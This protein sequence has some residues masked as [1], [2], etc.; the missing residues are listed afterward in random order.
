MRRYEYKCVSARTLSDPMYRMAGFIEPRAT[1]S[2]DSPSQTH[3]SGEAVATH[4]LPS[5]RYRTRSPELVVDDERDDPQS[6]RRHISVSQPMPH[7]DERN[8]SAPAELGPR[9]QVES[10][11]KKSMPDPHSQVHSAPSQF[12]IGS[13]RPYKDIA[14]ERPVGDIRETGDVPPHTNTKVLGRPFKVQWIKT[15]RLPFVRTRHLRNPWNHDRQIKV[16]RDG[17]ELDPDVGHQLLEEWNKP[18][19]SPASSKRNTQSNPKPHAN[20]SIRH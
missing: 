14:S 1:S 4:V 15:D 8:L 5:T 11:M 13:Y 3:V 16:A 20:Q 12:N 18:P 10:S 17:T 7:T 9:R 6:A 2:A 19:A